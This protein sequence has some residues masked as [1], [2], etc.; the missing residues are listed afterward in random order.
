MILF[1][2]F[3]GSAL[4]KQPPKHCVVQI[5]HILTPAQLLILYK[6]LIRPCMEYSPH[7]WGIENTEHLQ[8]ESKPISLI[9]SRPL[10]DSFQSLQHHLNFPSLCLIYCSYNGHY[11]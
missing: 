5:L 1:R 9:I 2:E 10:T 8:I 6:G 11:C 3:T 7:E 4:L